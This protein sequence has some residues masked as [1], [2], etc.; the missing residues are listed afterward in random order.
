MF[1]PLALHRLVVG[2]FSALARYSI[3]NPGCTILVAVHSN[4]K[5]CS[6]VLAS[7]GINWTNF[8]MTSAASGFTPALWSHSTVSLRRFLLGHR[9]WW[10]EPTFTVAFG[11]SSP[12]RDRCRVNYSSRELPSQS[13]C[14]GSIYWKTSECQRGFWEPRS[15]EQRTPCERGSLFLAGENS[16]V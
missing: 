8:A 16:R 12:L 3:H 6:R 4:I 11:R 9:P 15:E 14:W 1:K 13:P 10:I 7:R 5:T 2:C